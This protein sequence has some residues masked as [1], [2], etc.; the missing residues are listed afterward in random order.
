M[1]ILNHKYHPGLLPRTTLCRRIFIALLIICIGTFLSSSLHSQTTKSWHW[2]QQLGS[3]SWDRP[4][5]MVIDQKDKIYVAGTYSDKLIAGSKKLPA[6]GGDDIF[7]A[8][9]DTKGNI[10]SLIGIGGKGQDQAACLSNTRSGM[11][12]LAGI[13]TDSC[14]WNKKLL[15][16]NGTR[17]FFSSSNSKGGLNWI[18]YISILGNA[19]LTQIST[20][21]LGNVYATGNFTGTIASGDQKV[22]SNGRNDIFVVKLMPNGQINKLV[23][24]GSIGDEFVNNITANAQGELLI[25]GNFT[26]G[27]DIGD[28]QV[29]PGSNRSNFFI[30]KLNSSL[31]PLW[32]NVLTSDGLAG[33][34]SLAVD[35]SGCYYAGGSFTINLQLKDTAFK[36]QGQTDA[37]LLKYKVNGELD[38][39]KRI[40]SDQYDYITGLNI[41]NIGGIIA[42]GSVGDSIQV[43]SLYFYPKRQDDAA[44]IAQFTETGKTIWGDCISGMGRNF[45]KASALDKNGNL[46]YFGSF[47]QT[48]RKDVGELVSEGDQDLFLACYYN[49]PETKI[50]F[51][52]N[53]AIC[54]DGFAELKVENRYKFITWN[55]TLQNSYYLAN[56][57]GIY[58]VSI[59]DKKGCRYSD[60]IEVQFAERPL[61]SL[62]KDTSLYAGD[63]LLLRAPVQMTGYRWMDGSHE[64]LF[65]A[66]SQDNKAFS[67]YWIN[68]TDSLGC[69]WNDTIGVSYLNIPDIGEEFHPRLIVYPNP[70]TDVLKW[71][72]DVKRTCRLSFEIA[73]NSGHI[74]YQEKVERYDPFDE[75]WTDISNYP[76][77][78]YLIRIRNV[79]SGKVYTT[80]SVIKR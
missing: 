61:F 72:L 17:M 41:D 63:T 33:I 57:P 7:L 12:I 58:K 54:P 42:T 45:S 68:F 9:Y 50:E 71:K 51:S 44:F 15:E 3:S 36:S 37:F 24:F 64:N 13:L 74:L 75:K 11:V 60:S 73:D 28:M 6:Y 25:A 40:G 48:F 10:E 29:R 76:M 19:A 16:G 62:G 21:S 14:F 8:R 65:Y 39:V 38:F 55:D 69:S 20:D 4:A 67:E 77:G 26:S 49:C 66:C 59:I 31:D 22:T 18:S 53:R 52:G 30:T 23:S 32:N 56:K 34:S 35:P 47:G 43:D 78:S 5:G 79:S 2:A 46:Y 27:F 70:V 1:K 80:A